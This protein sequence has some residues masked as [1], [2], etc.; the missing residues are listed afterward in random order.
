MKK[1]VLVLVLLFLPFGAF[2][3]KKEI[4]PAP[5]PSQITQAKTVFLV[6]GGGSE[7]AYDA[8]YQEMKLWGKYSIV[9][10]PETADLIITI[11]Y[12]TEHNGSSGMPVYNSY[13]KQTTYYSSENIDP[14]LKLTIVD[15]KSKAE[16]WSSI[17]HRKLVRMSHNRDKEIVNS[18]TR[19][20]DELKA[21][22]Q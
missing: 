6:N 13:T 16:L 19:L 11:Q 7:V 9:G 14:Q 17:D 1:S 8:F 12:W 5:L 20:V 21:R 4:P 10:S 22:S 3:K 15:A 18:A 2:G